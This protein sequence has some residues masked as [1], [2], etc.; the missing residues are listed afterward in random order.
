M[1]KKFIRFLPALFWMIL[2]FYL[3]SRQ[4]SGIQGTYTQR[5]IILK[6]FH[7]VEYAI[8]YIL[9]FF[10]QKKHPQSFASTY[11]Y[12][13]TDEL[14]QTF[15]PGRMGKF[16]DTLIDILGMAIGFIV[17]KFALR[18]SWVKKLFD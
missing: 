2:I 5:F 4:T 10:A 8:L 14:H 9:M 16:S 11:L 3:S 17:L 18:L 15:T 12:A 13:L 6:F 1:S 7:L